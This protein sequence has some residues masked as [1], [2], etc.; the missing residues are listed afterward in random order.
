[1]VNFRRNFAPAATYFFTVTLRNRRSAVL[2]DHID[3]LGRSFRD[4]RAKYPF[5]TKAIVVLPDHLHALWTLPDG[6]TDYPRRWQGVKSRFTRALAKAGVPLTKDERGE[7]RLW[8][9]RF[10]EH[11]IVD[12]RDLQSHLDYIHYN[13]VKHGLVGRAADWPHSS[14]H[15]YAQAG[16][17][18]ENWGVGPKTFDNREFGEPVA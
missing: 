11:T 5:D 10:W 1:M 14:F 18:D 6:D 7:Y 3:L 9:R 12:E 8:Q 17:F 13:P 4:V 15:R 16:W 2:T